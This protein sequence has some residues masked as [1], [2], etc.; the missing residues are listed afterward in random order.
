MRPLSIWSL[1]IAL[2]DRER[3]NDDDEEEEEKTKDSI[4]I[5]GLGNEPKL[6]VITGWFAQKSFKYNFNVF[7]TNQRRSQLTVIT[8]GLYLYLIDIW[9][10][11]LLKLWLKFLA[12]NLYK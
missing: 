1:H 2:R 4:L 3:N 11:K 7:R 9:Y 8:D 12:E 5:W 6:N 10:S